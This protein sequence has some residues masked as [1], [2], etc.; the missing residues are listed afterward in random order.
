MRGRLLIGILALVLGCGSEVPTA[1]HGSFVSGVVVQRS[2]TIANGSHL[3]F[4]G[5]FQLRDVPVA[6][7]SVRFNY[8]LQGDFAVDDGY[9][10]EV[11]L[12]HREDVPRLIDGHEIVP[13]WRS[14]LT[15]SATW[16]FGLPRAGDYSLVLDNRVGE[17]E[18]KSV[19]AL[20]VL[21][22]DEFVPVLKP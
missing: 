10:M 22:W 2:K 16:A 14:G 5:Q 3:L 8:H 1:D 12:M 15:Q 21:T 11:F 4:P 13:V 17:A 20:A 7:D 18:W 6:A 9:S 19:T